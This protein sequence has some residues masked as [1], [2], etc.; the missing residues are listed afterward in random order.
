MNKLRAN[1]IWSV[2]GQVSFA[3]LSWGVTVLLARADPDGKLV[4]QYALASA[5]TLPILVLF[6]LQLRTVLVSDVGNE[7]RFADYFGLRVVTLL[8]AFVVMCLVGGL[9]NLECQTKLALYALAGV[10]VLDGTSDLVHAYFQRFEQLRLMALSLLMRGTLTVAGIYVGIKLVGSLWGSIFIVFLLILMELVFF[11]K[12]ALAKVCAANTPQN[13][14]WS[15]LMPRFDR[16][17]LKIIFTKSWPL[18][19]S[20][21]IGAFATQLPLYVIEAK[22]GS[23]ALGRFAVIYNP[24][25][26]MPIFIVAAFEGVLAQLSKA[27]VARDGLLWRN[28]LGRLLAISVVSAGVLIVGV[29]LLGESFLA[30]AYGPAYATQAGLFLLLSVGVGMGFVNTVLSAALLANRLFS[31]MMRLSLLQL[32]VAAALT[33]GL[34]SQFGDEGAA[35]ALMLGQCLSMVVFVV[36]VARITWWEMR[37]KS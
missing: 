37:G 9:A 19:V 6:N 12:A 22:F 15:L 35:Y 5:I 7:F 26:A 34:V 33:L 18:A 3:A 2:I 10:R 27:A 4:G 25:M 28:L 29:W 31:T 8:L 16:R 30:R 20:A 36:L 24:L 21:L 11:E 23:E 13:D 32:P 17:A 14:S 1:V